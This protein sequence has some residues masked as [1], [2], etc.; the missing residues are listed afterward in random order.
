MRWFG[1]LD[2]CKDEDDSVLA[3]IND[4]VLGAGEEVEM[5]RL[6][7][8]DLVLGAGEEVSIVILVIAKTWKECQT[9][10]EGH[11]SRERNGED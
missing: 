10:F 3:C 11:R 2:D 9:R 8:N 6:Y 5:R 7:R 1:H 4:L